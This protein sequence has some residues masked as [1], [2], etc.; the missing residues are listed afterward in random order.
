MKT[1]TRLFVPALMLA[2]TTGSAV[3]ARA[4]DRRGSDKDKHK[5]G[6]KHA[7]DVVVSVL[8]FR[9][10]RKWD[11]PIHGNDE[12]S[13]AWNV[14]TG[15]GNNTF[16]GAREF[17]NVNQSDYKLINQSRTFQNIDPRGTLKFNVTARETGGALNENALA[18]MPVTTRTIGTSTQP[19]K[20]ALTNQH[21]EFWVA[22]TVVRREHKHKR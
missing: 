5:H 22:Y 18:T 17:E 10:L 19:V 6:D 4:A 1:T 20:F 2:V 12:Y 14:F 16:P 11:A 9:P 13:V 7:Y 8:G 15:D 3:Q 21:Y